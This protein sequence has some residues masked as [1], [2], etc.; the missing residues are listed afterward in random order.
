MRDIFCH[1]FLPQTTNNHRPKILHHTS[2]LFLIAA[3]FF[4]GASAPKLKNDFSQVLGTT[5]SVSAKELLL[6][7]NEK[8]QE[9]GVNPLV[10]NEELSAAAL[11][12]ARHMFKDN[13]WAH[14]SPS[15]V[16]PWYF[17]KKVGYDYTYAGE[18][19]ARG[20]TVSQDVVDA[21]MDSRSHR[22]NMLSA[23]YHDVGFAIE[24]GTLGEE[25]TVLV[26]EMFGG[27]VIRPNDSKDTPVGIDV[28]SKGSLAVLP[29]IEKQ[30][31][32]DNFFAAKTIGLFVVVL[33]I[34]VL[35]SDLIIVKRKKL[36]RLVGHN[37]DHIFYLSTIVIFILLVTKG[38]IL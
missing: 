21:W 22:E 20:F 9:A 35:I 32:I 2:L 23:N 6:I 1:F 13:Y 14:N 28:V 38:G 8:R 31:F 27:K 3:L 12:K 29:S 25:N 36:I 34:S 24:Q 4:L 11:Q 30:S 18:N 37:L 10:I 26:V 33:F 7:T 19:L 15:G 5:I 17:F 16:T